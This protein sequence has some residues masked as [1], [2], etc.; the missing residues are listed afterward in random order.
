M[1]PK[2][3]HQ[4]GPADKNRWHPVWLRCYGSW[5]EQHSRDYTIKLW[6]DEEADDL[7]KTS[8]SEYFD[9]YKAFTF[10]ICRIDF[11]RFCI[12]HKFGGLYADLDYY[13]YSNFFNELTESCYVVGSSYNHEIVQNSLM[14]AE[15]NQEF[16]IECMEAS[17]RAFLSNEFSY[18]PN[19]VFSQESNNYVMDIT[20]PRLLSRLI[21]T[22]KCKV[23][24]MPSM[25]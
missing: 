11:V 25:V 16:F 1:I 18:T 23:F 13:C 15:P 20:G 17:K 24:I 2:I 8:Y 12:L 14:A 4:L 3:I 21:T 10:N 9:I 6:S 5:Q 7:V 19:N 22:T